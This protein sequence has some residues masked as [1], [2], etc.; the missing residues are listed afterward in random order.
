MTRTNIRL[1]N[2]TEQCR[3]S[4]RFL[5]PHFRSGIGS[6][7]QQKSC[8]GTNFRNFFPTFFV[9][10][11]NTLQKTTKLSSTLL[12]T[13]IYLQACSCRRRIDAKFC[14]RTHRL[15]RIASHASSS[16]SS[17]SLRRAALVNSESGKSRFCRFRFR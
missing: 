15:H 5:Q 7:K 6:K 8:R 3:N 11:R 10:A 9:P 13:L 14:V 17:T 12:P 2:S 16:A 1:L 4:Y